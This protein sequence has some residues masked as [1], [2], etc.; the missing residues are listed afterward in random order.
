MGVHILENSEDSYKCMYCSTSMWAFG[1]IFYEDE[2]IE[3][4]L[5]WLVIDPRTLSD[6]ELESK[7]SEW[8]RI[9]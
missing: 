2:D 9:K 1:P 7:V 4:F 3:E 5:K 8:R 6:N